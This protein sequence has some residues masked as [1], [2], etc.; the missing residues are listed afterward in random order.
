MTRAEL[1]KIC[2]SFPGTR[3]DVKWEQDLC[4]VVAEKMYCVT[5]MEGP[6][7]LSL[8]VQAEEMQELLEREGIVPA[9]YLAR[10]NW[11]LV[12]KPNAFT[13]K[14]WQHYLR[15]SYDLVVTK[16]PKKTQAKLIGKSSK[17]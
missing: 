4:Y 15:Q 5:N 3:Q 1:E 12:E 17:K 2:M 14:E 10:N 16:L 7:K 6:L 9:P 8:K 13:A 11:V